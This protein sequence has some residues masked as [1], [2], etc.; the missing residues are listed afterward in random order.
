LLVTVRYYEYINISQL[1]K[2]FYIFMSLMIRVLTPKGVIYNDKVEE[3]ILPCRNG[4]VGI[5]PGHAALLTAVDI[6]VLSFRRKDKSDW[7]A[8]ALIAGFARVKHDQV[9]ILVNR[10]HTKDSVDPKRAEKSLKEATDRLNTA[11][12]ELDKVEAS[13]SFKSARAIYQISQ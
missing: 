12:G 11:V 7:D 9:T 1:I 4:Q 5:L 3:L 2:I 10:A 8:I 13:L 6:N